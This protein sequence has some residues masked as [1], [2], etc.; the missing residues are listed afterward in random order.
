VVADDKLTPARRLF[1]GAFTVAMTA[2]GFAAGRFL[3]RPSEAVAQPIEFNHRLHVEE[4]GVECSTC[5]EYYETAQ[6]SGLPTLETCL[7][8][9]E[10]P[11][12]DS[13]EEQK[14]VELAQNDPRPEFQKLFRMPDHVYYSHREHV[15]I[16]GLACETCHGAVAATTSPPPT[17]LVRIT[18][19]TCVGCH[20][21]DGVNTDCTP[22]HR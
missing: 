19:D 7:T 9:H 21:K 17:A 8:C 2:V 10:E 22:C 5:H 15:A 3:L 16:A 20:E 12:T 1:I 13:A 18:M 14:L 4:V 6:H 11:M